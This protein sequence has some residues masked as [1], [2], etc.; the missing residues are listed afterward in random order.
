MMQWALSAFAEATEGK[1]D[2]F[3]WKR[4][5]ESM[6]NSEVAVQIVLEAEGKADMVVL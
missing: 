1:I 5:R 2:I 3:P 4:L 6:E